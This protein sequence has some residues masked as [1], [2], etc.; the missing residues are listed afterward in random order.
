MAKP[1]ESHHDDELDPEP[2]TSEGEG[3]DDAPGEEW[4]TVQLI[5]PPPSSAW[6]AFV[7]GAPPNAQ[8]TARQVDYF[9][10]QHL[11]DDA[12]DDDDDDAPPPA[13]S[14]VVP[15][16]ITEIGEVVPLMLDPEADTGTLTSDF[17]G[18]SRS[19]EAA[20]AYGAHYVSHLTKSLASVAGGES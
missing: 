7:A 5:A 12:G 1:A 13:A 19:Q 16:V 15:V 14:R 18:L 17:V 8:I 10:V 6:A 20:L 3:D 9:A 4:L 2:A 11:I